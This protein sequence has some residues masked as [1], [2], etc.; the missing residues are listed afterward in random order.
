MYI[1]KC[2]FCTKPCGNSHCAYSLDKLN[3]DK[4]KKDADNS[5]K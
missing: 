4:N 5:S 3:S 2:P 1:N